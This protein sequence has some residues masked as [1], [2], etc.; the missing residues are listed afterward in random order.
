M[1]KLLIP[2]MLLSVSILLI[3][4]SGDVKTNGEHVD[5]NDSKSTEE[6]VFESDNGD[7][8]V[9]SDSLEEAEPADSDTEI[10]S[11]SADTQSKNREESTLSQYS[12]KEIEYARVW[13]QLIGNKEASKINVRQISAGEPVN[14]YD[15]D[16]AVYPESVIVLTGDIMADGTVTYSGNGDGTINIYDIP[17]HWPSA[18]QLELSMKEYTQKIISD[19]EKMYINPGDDEAVREL[20]E[21]LNS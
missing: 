9:S 15:E 17:L 13:L 20:V 6:K 10:S 8:S 21:K 19:T 5:T 7:E 14:P 11:E 3:S 1:K 12:S 2:I 4:C 16:S 18:Q